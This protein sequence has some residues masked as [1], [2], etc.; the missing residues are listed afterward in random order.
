[1]ESYFSTYTGNDL[2]AA[3]QFRRLSE[4]SQSFRPQFIAPTFDGAWTNSGTPFA[5]AGYYK[6]PFERVWLQGRVTG[7]TAGTLIFTLP[8]GFRVL[9]QDRVFIALSNSVVGSIEVLANG[10]VRAGIYSTW[11][12]L[13]GIS[14]AAV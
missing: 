5:L 2:S 9:D 1:M 13:D 7:G 10:N 3:E 11:I 14:F 12:S 6:D 8:L 4:V